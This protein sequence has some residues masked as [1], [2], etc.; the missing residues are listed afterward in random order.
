MFDISLSGACC[1]RDDEDR[2]SEGGRAGG[3][4][5]SSV[6]TDLERAK[7]LVMAP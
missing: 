5:G 7:K 1:T 3:G 4:S 6:T 2:L